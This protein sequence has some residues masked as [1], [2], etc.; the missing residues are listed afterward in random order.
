MGEDGKTAYQT[1]KGRK[2]ARGIAEFGECV[3]YCRLGSKGIDKFDER[4]EE[5][6]WLGAKDESDEILIG[7]NKGVVKARAVRRK[8]NFEERW[9]FNQFNE[10]KGAPWEPIPGSNSIEIK[11]R[12]NLEERSQAQITKEREEGE[13]EQHQFRR[14]SIKRKDVD[15]IGLTP[16]CRGCIAINRKN[17]GGKSIEHNE[18]CR[19]RHENKMRKMGDARIVQQDYRLLKYGTRRR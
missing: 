8:S 1:W 6:I 13:E 14:A 4:W 16:G 15:I 17:P 5:G 12:V 7:T 19:K 9:N 11:S 18:E 2:Y 3:I 10:I